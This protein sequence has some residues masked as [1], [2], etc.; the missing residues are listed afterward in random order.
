MILGQEFRH[1]VEFND[2]ADFLPGHYEG[3]AQEFSLRYLRRLQPQ[4][5]YVVNMTRREVSEA[6]LPILASLVRAGP[7]VFLRQEFVRTADEH[8]AIVAH[9]VGHIEC[10][11]TRTKGVSEED[12]I[13]LEIEADWF[14]AVS[15]G[16][17]P[18][19]R[20]LVEAAFLQ[21]G[22]LPVYITEAVRL[23]DEEW[24]LEKTSDH[25][26]TQ[27]LLALGKHMQ[28]RLHRLKSPGFHRKL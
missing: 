12:R 3:E 4:T 16:P 10:G 1:E 19:F 15:V 18:V 13:P 2:P 22:C 6:P 27:R 21:S 5:P 7:C 28:L 25:S 8:L 26:L 24:L 14:A 9:E 17:E 20:S 23:G 11:H